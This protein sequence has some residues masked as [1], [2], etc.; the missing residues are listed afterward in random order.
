MIKSVN[1]IV[2]IWPYVQKLNVKKNSELGSYARAI[3]IASDIY[4]VIFYAK[5]RPLWPRYKS[6]VL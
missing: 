1:R 6:Q 5:T 4:E 3:T 2:R